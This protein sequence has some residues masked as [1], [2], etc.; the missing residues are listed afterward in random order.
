VKPVVVVLIAQAVWTL[1]KTA[2][3]SRELMVIA[4]IV[5]GLAAMRVS[6]LALLI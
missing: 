4:A 2:L 5:L 3:K 1:R 6:T